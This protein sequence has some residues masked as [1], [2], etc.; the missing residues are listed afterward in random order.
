MCMCQK[1]GTPICTR[2]MALLSSIVR[3][4]L[5]SKSL[6]WPFLRFPL[7]KQE[8]PLVFV[9]N[10]DLVNTS[11]SLVFEHNAGRMMY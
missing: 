9:D 5:I 11:V 6:I 8:D 7:L 2:A 3:R 10:L 1:R 4:M